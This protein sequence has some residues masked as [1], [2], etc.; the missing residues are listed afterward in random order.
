MIH[1][2]D[3][4]RFVLSGIGTEFRIACDTPEEMAQVVNSLGKHA[5]DVAVTVTICSNV[6]WKEAKEVTDR[7]NAKLDAGLEDGA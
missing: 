4:H 5:E 6:G 3:F 1:L 2:Q 7:L